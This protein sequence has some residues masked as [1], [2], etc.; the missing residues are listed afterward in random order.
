[1]KKCAQCN[2]DTLVEVTD[3]VND[4]DGYFFVLRGWR[5]SQCGEEY[6]DEEDTQRM[7]NT[8]RHLGAWA[9]PLKLHR[10]LSKS[11]RGTVLRIPTDI[12]H[13][14]KLKGNEDVLISKI[15]KNKILLEVD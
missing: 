8:A 4:L 2:K 5:C 11:G 10:K 15:G 13:N 12:E 1:M 9:Q 3:I 7:I 6:L 14:L